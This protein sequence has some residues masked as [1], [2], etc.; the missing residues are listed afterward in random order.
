MTREIPGINPEDINFIAGQIGRMSDSKPVYPAFDPEG[1][2]VLRMQRGPLPRLG[3]PRGDDTPKV[4]REIRE[5]TDKIIR[6]L[7]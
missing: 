5:A 6:R 1:E 2:N 4:Q 3:M 7:S